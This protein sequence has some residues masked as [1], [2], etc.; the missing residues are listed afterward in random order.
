MDVGDRNDTMIQILGGVSEGDLLAL[1]ARTRAA[2][3]TKAAEKDKKPGEKKA[4][5]DSPKETSPATE[6]KA[7]PVSAGSS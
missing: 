6:A 4:D 2:A 5:A 3:D 1:D 7:A